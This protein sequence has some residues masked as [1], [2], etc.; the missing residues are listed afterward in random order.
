MVLLLSTL[1][2]LIL[3]GGLFATIALAGKGD[4]DYFKSTK[5]NVT[6]LTSIYIVLLIVI[7]IGF[8]I[9]LF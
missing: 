6:R 8:A 9:Y 2:I 7:I 5:G 1:G 3:L 4:Q